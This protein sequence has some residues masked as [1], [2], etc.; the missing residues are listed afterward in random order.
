[1]RWFVCQHMPRGRPFCNLQVYTKFL[2]WK[3]RADGRP[4]RCVLFRTQFGRRAGRL[5]VEVAAVTVINSY[6]LG[7][8][9]LRC[10]WNPF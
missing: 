7:R 10:S 3:F 6:M 9:G 4:H 8:S 2:K 5:Q 1:M